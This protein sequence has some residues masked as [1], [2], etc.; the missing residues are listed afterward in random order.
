MSG[1]KTDGSH[2]STIRVNVDVEASVAGK[3]TIQLPDGTVVDGPSSQKFV[4]ID[5]DELEVG[6]WLLNPMT[7]EIHKVL[8]WEDDLLK[9]TTDDGGTCVLIGAALE[10][11]LKVINE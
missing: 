2:T 6:D 11:L 8:I 9:I 3:S 1:V 10:I 7:N 5:P 4:R